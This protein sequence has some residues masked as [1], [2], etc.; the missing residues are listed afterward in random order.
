MTCQENIE[1]TKIEKLIF[2]ILTNRG[3]LIFPYRIFVW[4]YVIVPVNDVATP[5][6][7]SVL[8]DYIVKYCQFISITN[9]Q[10]VDN[11][12]IHF[13]EIGRTEIERILFDW[14]AS[15]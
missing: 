9:G 1:M 7:N 13:F 4:F 3:H 15:V 5:N 12:F 2:Q 14:T 8:S 10:N 6:I 11:R